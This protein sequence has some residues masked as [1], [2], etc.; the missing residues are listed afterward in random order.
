MRRNRESLA[1]AARQV[2][3]APRKVLRHV[4]KALVKRRNRY[5]AR[6]GDQ[7]VRTLKFVTSDK[8]QTDIR[9][10]GSR[11]ASLVGEY[12]SAVERYLLTGDPDTLQVFAGKSIRVG[13]D[14]YPFI[15]DFETLEL[16]SYAGQFQF[17]DL[18]ILK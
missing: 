11:K 15:T 1:H 13:K 3:I 2:Q 4:G 18:Y 12:F 10:R 14:T 16:L 17:E 5:R 6:P 8:G 9:V 7:L